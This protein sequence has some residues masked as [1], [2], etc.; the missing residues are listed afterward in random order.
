MPWQS[1][2][3]NKTAQSGSYPTAR[4]QL[5]DDTRPSGLGS[6]WPDT[7]NQERGFKKPPTIDLWDTG[8]WGSGFLEGRAV[9]RRWVYSER[10]LTCWEMRLQGAA[11]ENLSNGHFGEVAEIG[12]KVLWGHQVIQV[13]GL[14][15]A[16]K[17]KRTGESTRSLLAH[18]LFGKL[19]SLAAQIFQPT[20]AGRRQEVE[21]PP[22]RMFSPHVFFSRSFPDPK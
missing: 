15:L 18:Q 2:R 5:L 11:Q 22:L 21:Y 7:S 1:T 16:W 9:G 8:G 12:L 4:C 20:Q 13:G 6:N 17:G 3:R 10:V 14:P 19:V